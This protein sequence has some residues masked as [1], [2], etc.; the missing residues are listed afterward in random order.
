MNDE[1]EQVR[2]AFRELGGELISLGRRLRNVSRR[3][4]ESGDLSAIEHDMHKA[5]EALAHL[6]AA[7]KDLR[8]S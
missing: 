1:I 3:S 5:S 2:R 6:A 8:A 4:V 7:L